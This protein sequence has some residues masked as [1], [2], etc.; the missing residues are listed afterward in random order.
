M[1]IWKENNQKH[2]AI[3]QWMNLFVGLTFHFMNAKNNAHR[4]ALSNVALQMFIDISRTIHS[5]KIYEFEIA[6]KR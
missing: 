6:R 3:A 1:I 5:I 4:I 2:I